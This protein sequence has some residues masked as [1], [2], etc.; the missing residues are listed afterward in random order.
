V[1]LFNVNELKVYE[2]IVHNYVVLEGFPWK[3][4]KLWHGWV[5][6]ATVL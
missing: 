3:R 6:W 2:V 1:L 4:D 5:D